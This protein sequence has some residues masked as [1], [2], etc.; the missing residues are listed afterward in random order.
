MANGTVRIE[1]HPPGTT[2]EH[3]GPAPIASAT[4]T[5]A[6]IT[7]TDPA[8]LPT[9]GSLLGVGGLSGP[10]V[11]FITPSSDFQ[12]SLYC[13]TGKTPDVTKEPRHLLNWDNTGRTRTF[14]VE[15]GNNDRLQLAGVA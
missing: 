14:I 9:I 5:I 13:A 8:A 11:A 12:A 6:G 7:P 3:R 4:L 10:C 2:P 1:L 15:I